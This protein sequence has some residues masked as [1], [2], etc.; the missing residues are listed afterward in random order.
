MVKNMNQR[1]RTIRL[2][3]VLGAT[4]GRVH[5]MA[6]ETPREAIR[7]LCIVIPGFERFLNSS[8]KRGLTYAVFGK[9]NLVHDELGWI[10]VKK[11]Y[12]LLQ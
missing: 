7:A 6:V 10:K 11:T 2:Y 3:G 12:V 1:I 4:F 8:R 5:K 9:R